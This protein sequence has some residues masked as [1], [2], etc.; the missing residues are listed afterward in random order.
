[1]IIHVFLIVVRIATLVPICVFLSKQLKNFRKPDRDPGLN[2]T[3]RSLFLVNLAIALENVIFLLFEMFRI[4]Q[5]IEIT[6]PF[7]VIMVWGALRL[8]ML[9]AVWSFFSLL[10]KK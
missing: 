7:S 4:T 8:F 10:Y 6:T 5:N 9:Y 1:M 3:R 2:D